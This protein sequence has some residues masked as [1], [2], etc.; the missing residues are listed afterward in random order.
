VQGVF[1]RIWVRALPAVH[2]A[3]AVFFRVSFDD[4]LEHSINLN[5]IPPSGLRNQTPAIPIT[6][7]PTNV[8]QG[9]INIEGLPIPEEGRYEIQLLIDG[10]RV[11][12]YTLDVID[13]REQSHG[14][15]H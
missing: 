1:D 14:T 5:V 15:T 13:I 8:A 2:R 6:V 7:G 9:T 3:C 12:R 4:Q 10:T 11:A